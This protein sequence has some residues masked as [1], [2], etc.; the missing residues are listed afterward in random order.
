MVDVRLSTRDESK[1]RGKLF[2]IVIIKTDH[3]EQVINKNLK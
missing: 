3:D 1:L 2:I